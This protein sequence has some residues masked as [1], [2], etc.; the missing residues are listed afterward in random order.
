MPI[1]INTKKENII[2]NIHG[3]KIVDPYRWLEDSKNPEVKKWIKDQ[4]DIV[5]RFLKNDSYRV[6]SEELIKNFKTTTFSNPLPI[7]GK[8]FYTERKPDEDQG[9]LYYKVGLAGLPIKLI[10]PNGEVDGNTITIDF[11]SVS[12]TGK[13]VA[14]GISRGGDEK[15]TLF[16]KDIDKNEQFSESIPNCRYSSVKWLPDDSGFF[17]T[18]NPRPGTVS[19]TDEVLYTKV[20]FHKLGDD[21]DGDTLIFGESRPKD[22]MIRLKISQDGRFLAIQVG[23]N[24]LENEIFIYDT[25]NKSLRLLVTGFKAKFHVSFLKDKVLIMTDYQA[26]NYKILYATYESMYKPITEWS[27]FIPE[28]NNLLQSFNVTSNKILAEYLVNACS[29]VCV[30]DYNGKELQKISLPKYSSIS[31]ISSNRDEEEFFYGVESFTFPK[32]IYRYD[33]QKDSYG[34]YR[35]IDNPINPSDFEI[36]QE[37]YVSKDGTKVPMFI[38]YKKGLVLNG[39]NPTI[40]YGYG[41]FG[42]SQTP[43]FMRNWVPW[44]NRGGVFAIANIRGGGE[45]GNSWHIAGI[46]ENKQNS[47]DDF[48]SAGEY[49]IDKKYTSSRYLGI[50]GGSNGG[51]LVSAVAIQAPKLFQA[52]CSRVPLIDMVRFHKFGMAMRWVNEYGNPEIRN[53]LE[54]ILKW[55]PYHNVKQDIEYP[56]FL[57]TTADK[58]SRVD[59]F[60]ARKMTALLQEVNTKNDVLLLTEFDVGHGRGKPIAKIVEMQAFVLSFFYKYLK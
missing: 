60:H 4:N 8:Y 23:Q 15:S 21:P 29:E 27:E 51:L 6:F 12:K 32:I 11:W 49:L 53:E 30:F 48:I 42:N 25:S 37:W 44:I 14:Y 10:D 41:G 9:V 50:L 3:F 1:K 40:L 26:S 52:V 13:Y 2:E 34:E 46:K 7:N 16:I 43:S 17:Y 39:K 22:D 5:D 54:N 47:F 38:F 19:I 20:Y 57:L 36:K 28:R 18:R 24:W 35:K 33:P 45:F 55:S 58:D 31:G 56:N 59:P